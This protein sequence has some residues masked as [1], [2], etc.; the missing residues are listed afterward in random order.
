[1]TAARSSQVVVEVLRTNTAAK[2]F[3][4]QVA[5]EVLRINN[6]TVIRSSQISVEVLRPSVAVAAN[7]RPVIFVST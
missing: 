1:M 3:A 5:V 7:Q 4:S 2:A 6:G